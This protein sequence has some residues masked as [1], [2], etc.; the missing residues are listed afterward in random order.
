[1]ESVL[2]LLK[3]LEFIPIQTKQKAQE[4]LFDSKQGKKSKQRAK[5]TTYFSYYKDSDT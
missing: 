2:C 1:M 3:D 4:T 5:L